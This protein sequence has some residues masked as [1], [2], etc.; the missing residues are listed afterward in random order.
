MLI[1]IGKKHTC[2]KGKCRSLG[3]GF[4]ETGVEVNADK[5]INGYV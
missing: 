1:H 3:S 4:K 5:L 2:Y